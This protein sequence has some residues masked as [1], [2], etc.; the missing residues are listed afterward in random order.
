MQGYTCN[1]LKSFDS[2]LNASPDILL[3]F[4]ASNIH[5]DVVNFRDGHPHTLSVDT[6]IL[7]YGR[8]NS[9]SWTIFAK[10]ERVG[11]SGIGEPLV[12]TRPMIV[13]KE[14]VMDSGRFN[15]CCIEGGMRSFAL[16]LFSKPAP[17][18]PVKEGQVNSTPIYF[19]PVQKP[20][21]ISWGQVGGSPKRQTI[22]KSDR[23]QMA[24]I[25]YL[26]VWAP[27]DSVV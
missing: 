25:E 16:T 11:I 26:D 17:L 10:T 15:L 9:A 23:A 18:R 22:V 8:N 5:R 13:S 2:L 12:V 24:F 7:L 19:E 21:R 1:S 20:G 27:L 4:G 6:P 14:S 3:A